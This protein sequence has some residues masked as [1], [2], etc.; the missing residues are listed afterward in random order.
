MEKEKKEIITLMGNNINHLSHKER[1]I[2]I[3]LK[4][5]H[6]ESTPIHKGSK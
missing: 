2:L 4:E 3:K 1:A 5:E 6:N